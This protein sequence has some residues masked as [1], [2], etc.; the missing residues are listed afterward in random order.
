MNN[1]PFTDP[2]IIF[3]LV[4]TIILIAPLAMHRMRMPGLIGLI[5]AGAIVGPS[6]FHL[7]ERDQTIELLGTVGLLYLMFMAGL[8]M[9]LNQFMREKTKSLSFGFLSFMIPQ[10]AGILVGLHILDYS[11]LSSVL[12]GSIVGSHTLLAYPIAK[13]LGINKNPAVTMSLGGTIVTD[14]L[15]LTVLAVVVAM[16][17]G[18]IGT[19]FWFQFLGSISCFIIVVV[20]GLPMLGKWF[21]RN[22][23]DSGD[24]DFTFL[25]V[26]LFFAAVLSKLVG[27]APIVGAFVAGLSMNKL[28]PESGPLMNRIQ[29]VGEA[30]FIPFFLISVGMLVDFGVIFGSLEVWWTAIC[31]TALVLAGKTTAAFVAKIFAGQSLPEMLTVAGLTIPQAAATLA[32]TLVGFDLGFFDQTAVNAVVLLMLLTCLY[33]TIFVERFGRQVALQEEARPFV[34]GDAPQRILVPLANE[35]TADRLMDIAFMVRQQGSSEPV[36]PLTVARDDGDV[37]AQVAQAE[38]ILGSAV[39]HAASADVP[40][41]PVTRVD[42]HIAHGILRAIRERRITGIVLGWNG[43]VTTSQKILGS[44]LD[45]LIE[46]S[47]EL[48]LVC[49]FTEMPINTTQRVVLIIP[50]FAEREPGFPGAIV[51]IKQL[52]SQLGAE[53]M[54]FVREDISEMLEASIEEIKPKTAIRV[55]PLSSWAHLLTAL[56]EVVENDDLLVLMSTR[57]DRIS[58]T[59]EIDRLPRR[60]AS[61]FGANNFMTVFPSEI[62][63]DIGL[64]S[65]TDILRMLSEERMLP[66]IEAQDLEGAIVTLLGSHFRDQTLDY[67]TRGF[68]ANAVQSS[69]EVRPGLALFHRH[70]SP[71]KK[72]MIFIAKLDQELEVPGIKDKIKLLVIFLSPLETE[73]ERHLQ[74]ISLLARILNRTSVHE[75]LLASNTSIEMKDSFSK[76]G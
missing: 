58:W 55:H 44:V 62:R 69:T 72:P 30:L 37:Q 6:A 74:Y 27:L 20:F 67:L 8:S 34:V 26:V 73:P 32:V 13:R 76:E 5:V 53:L 71:V 63:F 31:F 17:A 42:L 12:L 60:L 47:L 1:L 45:E 21:F 2:V 52:V 40:V 11:L 57:I 29:F 9:D 35:N 36:Y 22:V 24:S 14:A 39:I 59:P 4:M 38:K 49:R 66:E 61:R 7:L 54:I 68:V 16:N 15:A 75:R 19:A 46:R 3:A 48:I 50:R 51:A 43:Y 64:K 25:L 70:V 65:D 28:V 23:Q 10:V 33:G 56:G 18:E 41:L